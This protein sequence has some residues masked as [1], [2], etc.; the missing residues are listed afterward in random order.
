M[1]QHVGDGHPGRAAR[2]AVAAAGPTV[3]LCIPLDVFRQYVGVNFRNCQTEKAPPAEPGGLPI[4]LVD[5]VAELA[6]LIDD[7]A[8]DTRLLDCQPLDGRA[9]IG[10]DLLLVGLAEESSHIA[11]HVL[12][13]RKTEP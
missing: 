12:C 10:R 13:D 1:P 5:R 8:F 2:L 6:Q 9:V 7:L 4:G 11:V 3:L